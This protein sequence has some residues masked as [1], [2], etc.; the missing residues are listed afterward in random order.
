MMEFCISLLVMTYVNRYVS[1]HAAAPAAAPT[2]NGRSPRDLLLDI[3]RGSL[4]S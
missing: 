3:R 2:P 4:A 1:T